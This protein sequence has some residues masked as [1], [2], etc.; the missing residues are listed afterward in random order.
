LYG[1]GAGEG[2]RVDMLQRLLCS[3]EGSS[4]GTTAPV[5]GRN[6]CVSVWAQGRAAARLA[7]LVGAA[8]EK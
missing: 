3:E 5:L 2:V 1:N 8:E 7:V 6:T 4:T